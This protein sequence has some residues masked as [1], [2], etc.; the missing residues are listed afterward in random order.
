MSKLGVKTAK[1]KAVEAVEAVRLE[2]DGLVNS[3][4]AAIMHESPSETH[5][6][7]CAEALGLMTVEDLPVFATV[8]EMLAYTLSVEAVAGNEKAQTALLDRFSPKPAREATNVN[9]SVGDGAAPAVASESAEEAKAARDYMSM[10]K[11]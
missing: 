2:A 9:V 1:R 6:V 5:R 10:L 7:R 11:H 8:A 4:L 3:E